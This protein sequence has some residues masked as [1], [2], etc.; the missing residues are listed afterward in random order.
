MPVDVLIDCGS[1]ISLMS[2][3]LLKHFNCACKPAFCVLR[4]LGGQELESTSFVTLPIEFE[5]ITLEVDLFIVA[6]EFMNTP[7]IVG[8]DVLNRDGVRQ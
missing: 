2:S 3:S 8:T 1:T 4:G 5:G 7:V 6:S